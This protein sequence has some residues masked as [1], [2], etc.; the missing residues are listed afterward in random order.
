MG[1]T[2][3]SPVKK[4][5]GTVTLYDPLSLPQVV[6][7]EDAFAQVKKLGQKIS[8]SKQHKELLPAIED[9]VASWDLEG[10]KNPPSPFPATPRKPANQL[11]NW[12]IEEVTALF[13]E[14]EEKKSE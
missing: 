11:L 10:I 3:K 5:P 12:L 6:A 13:S 8:L 9:C 7:L 4:W 2:I 1:K 14:D